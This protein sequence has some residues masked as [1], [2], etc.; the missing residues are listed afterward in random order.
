[1]HLRG[2]VLTV[3]LAVVCVVDLMVVLL[4]VVDGLRVRTVYGLIVVVAVVL[5]RDVVGGLV[6]RQ[7]DLKSK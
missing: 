5:G 7:A 6:V 3:V 4:T 2:L 1:M